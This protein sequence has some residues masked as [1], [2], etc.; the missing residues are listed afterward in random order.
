MRSKKRLGGSDRLWA[1]PVRVCVNWAAAPW[2]R[3]GAAT[4]RPVGGDGLCGPSKSVHHDGAAT[5]RPVGSRKAIF[6]PRKRGDGNVAM[7]TAPRCQS[8]FT[9]AGRAHETP[10][11]GPRAGMRA[12]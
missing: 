8:G 6:S 10:R 3:T 7:R 9:E 5:P 12:V 1:N 4:P 11:A 2:R